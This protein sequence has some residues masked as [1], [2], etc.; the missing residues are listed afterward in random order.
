MSWEKKYKEITSGFYNC[1]EDISS[2]YPDCNDF[3]K[4]II[5]LRLKG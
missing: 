3:E 2:D 4:C 5:A 1:A